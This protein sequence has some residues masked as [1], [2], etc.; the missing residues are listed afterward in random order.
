MTS[1]T[2]NYTENRPLEDDELD[3]IHGGFSLIEL[4]VRIDQISIIMGMQVP[5]PQKVRDA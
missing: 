2:E 3:L 4:L 1:K 5:T